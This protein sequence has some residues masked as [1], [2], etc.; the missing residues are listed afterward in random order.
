MSAHRLGYRYCFSPGKE[1]R[2][3]LYPRPD[4]HSGLNMYFLKLYASVAPLTGREVTET[5]KS[6]Y[7]HPQIIVIC[8]MLIPAKLTFGSGSCSE[9]VINVNEFLRYGDLCSLV[10]ILPCA[11]S[12]CSLSR[13]TTS[14]TSFF[15][16]RHFRRIPWLPLGRIMGSPI[17]IFFSGEYIISL[18]LIIDKSSIS[19]LTKPFHKLFRCSRAIGELLSPTSYFLCK[20][21]ELLSGFS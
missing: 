20:G 8:K 14:V 19:K 10:C 12:S 1:I 13:V 16:R 6:R 9:R 11:T 2:Q 3:Y 15:P 17:G 18:E 5:K 4:V 7:K 21:T